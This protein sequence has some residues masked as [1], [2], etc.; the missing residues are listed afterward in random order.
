MYSYERATAKNGLFPQL[1][2][3]WNG[4]L[5]TYNEDPAFFR[6]PFL[7]HAEK[8]SGE[9]PAPKNY[10]IFLLKDEHGEFHALFHANVARLPQTDG[11]TLRIL[12]ILAAPRYEYEDV[13]ETDMAL[14]VSSILMAALDLVGGTM[15]ANH[16]KVRLEGQAERRFAHGLAFQLKGKTHAIVE[17][18]GTWLHMDSLRD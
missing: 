9:K 4:H 13:S 17:V 3:Q 6:V 14:L 10:G 1:R 15:N 7:D 16:L 2:T 18:R 5:A 12:W 11:K 8:I